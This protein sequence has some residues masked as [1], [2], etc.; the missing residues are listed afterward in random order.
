MT[1]FKIN[2]IHA[3]QK[4]I[5]NSWVHSIMPAVVPLRIM[6]LC[7]PKG[8]FCLLYFLDYIAQILLSTFIWM[9]THQHNHYG[10]NSL[11]INQLKKGLL[12]QILCRAVQIKLYKSYTR[13]SL[14]ILI[15]CHWLRQLF[16]GSVLALNLS[17]GWCMKYTTKLQ[18]GAYNGKQLLPEIRCKVKV[19]IMDNL[20]WYTRK[21]HYMSKK[22]LGSLG[23]H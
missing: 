15:N 14:S 10:P 13:N 20:V 16:Y 9:H 4:R 21:S 11:P 18:Y 22:Q 3:Q 23:C 1:T 7:M 19:L 12:G 8:Y 5:T 2:V 6:L 17:I